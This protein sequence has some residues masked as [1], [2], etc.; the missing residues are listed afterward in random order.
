MLFVN[1]WNKVVGSVF[2]IWK[3]QDGLELIWVSVCAVIL[4]PGEGLMT[5]GQPACLQAKIL[6]YFSIL[7]VCV[8]DVLYMTKD[9]VL[10][11]VQMLIKAHISIYSHLKLV[12]TELSRYY[13]DV[14][15]GFFSSIKT[16]YNLQGCKVNEES[17]SSS[18]FI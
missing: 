5:G 15:T 18:F 1:D 12:I 2:W 3:Y 11:I 4:S 9:F 6:F 13:K 10:K 8:L 17:D 14:S 16:V 7:F